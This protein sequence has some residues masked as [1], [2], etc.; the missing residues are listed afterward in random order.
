M[1]EHPDFQLFRT[2]VERARRQ[3]IEGS[4]LL[5]LPRQHFLFSA[6]I[7]G[8]ALAIIIALSLGSYTRSV[9]VRGILE[10][11]VPAAKVVAIRAG[12]LNRLLV[13]EGQLVK[14]GQ[15][16]A[17]VVVDQSS[18]PALSPLTRSLDAIAIQRDDALQRA[19]LAAETG[20][21]EQDS[22]RAQL[23]GIGGQLKQLEPQI[24]TEQQLQGSL[25]Q[26][27]EQVRSSFDKGF[28][29]RAEYD[30]RLQALT[31]ARQQTQQLL[32]Q[33][34]NLLAQRRQLVANLRR[35]ASNSLSEVSSQHA[36]ASQLVQQ[37]A[38]V[39]SQRSYSIVAPISGRVTALQ[40]SEGSAVQPTVPILIVV[41]EGSRLHANLYAQ[42]R[43]IGFVH[44]GQEVRLL[45]DA[46]PY[47]KFGSFAG[48]IRSVSRSVIDPRDVAAPFKF[49]E[50]VYRIEVKPLAQAVDAF[51]QPH[52][53][54]SG[55]TLS[56][57]V[58]LDRRSLADWLLEPIRAVL[59]KNQ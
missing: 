41:P 8:V 39:E 20:A 43:A 29:T 1:G 35:S 49:D 31:T 27:F 52:R 55:M 54:Q 4:V 50:P 26:S 51:G 48:R 19:N 42:T 14:A 32:S 30:R 46:Y 56:A 11:D 15:P 45:Y 33:R 16:I 24:A 40:A 9:L 59:R 12:V 34:A 18:Q 44:E 57:S 17:T 53:L 25:E 28:V 38:E 36:L 2:E 10:T 7:F 21:A 58:V 47:Q 5:A 3:R 13:R 23:Q 22:L 6:L 37:A